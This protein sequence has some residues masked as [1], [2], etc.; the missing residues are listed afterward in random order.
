MKKKLFLLITLATILLTGCSSD[1]NTIA[2]E[3]T[4]QSSSE[5]I[6]SS[7]ETARR[8][9][10]FNTTHSWEA[11]TAGG[12]W[13]NITPK[14]GAAGVNNLTITAEANNTGD[15]RTGTIVLHTSGTSKTITI[16]QGTNNLILISEKTHNLTATERVIELAITT[17]I[18]IEQIT[19]KD[20]ASWITLESASRGFTDGKIKLRISENTAKTERSSTFTLEDATTGTI[21]E[22]IQITQAGGSKTSTDYSAD[23]EVYLLQKATVGAGASIV[24]LGD[25]FVDSEI[26][27]GTYRSVMNKAIENLFTEE[28]MKSLRN[29]FTIHTV[30]AVSKN[31]AYGGNN[32]TAFSCVLAGGNSTGISGD[33]NACIEYALQ[34]PDININQ[35]LIIVILNSN[36]Y[37]GTAY[38]GFQTSTGQISELGI[39]YCPIIDNLNSESFRQVLV[40]EA[41]GHAYTK[42]FDEYS[43]ESQGTMPT[44]E[45]N[46]I[47]QYQKNY[48]WAMNID[49][50]ANPAE[51]VWAKFINDSRYN[52]ENI[53]VYEGAGTYIKGAYRPTVNS[54]M[55][56]NTVGF[57]A[58][59]RES[60]YKRTMNLSS[61]GS[62]NYDYETFVAFDLS[63]KQAIKQQS[64]SSRSN[65]QV[66]LRPTPPVIVNER[67]PA[68]K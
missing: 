4:L 59:S 30:N 9:I 67:M 53:G 61:N 56:N 58:P 31:N 52:W 64:N 42:L 39:G 18:A 27:D 49:T 60:I 23:G 13:F 57:N 5:I 35:T 28:P 62:F 45:Q 26:A 29:H 55:N 3:I 7:S 22:Q 41:A 37:A 12:N 47:K 54:M 36:A 66:N 19:L 65:E 11:T 48:G 6:L 14:Q 10:T 68:L 50:S 21:S 34:V 44:S 32:Q 63:Y 24:I 15:P 51:V 38:F 17:N 16:Q 46:K 20:A 8:V 33:H 40:H 43:Y 1:D 2:P 25:A